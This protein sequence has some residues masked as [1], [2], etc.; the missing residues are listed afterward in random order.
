VETLFQKLRRKG[1]AKQQKKLLER[2]NN[3]DH[4]K[5]EPVVEPRDPLTSLRERLGE[6]KKANNHE[7]ARQLRQDIWVLQDTSA[8]HSPSLSAEEVNESLKRISENCT[9]TDTQ[10]TNNQ[11]KSSSLSPIEKKIRNLEK[12]LQQIYALKA[13]LENGEKLEQTQIS[14]INSEESV[15]K[16]IEEMQHALASV[17]VTM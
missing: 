5:E 9:S 7:L 12:K 17:S 3:E 4:N 15:K 10:N 8:G 6:A 11:E 14:K 2:L 13:K 16:E 1:N